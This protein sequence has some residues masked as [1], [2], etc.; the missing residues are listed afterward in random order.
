MVVLA[1]FQQVRKTIFCT[2][3]PIKVSRQYVEQVKKG[4][5]V[6]IALHDDGRVMLRRLKSGG[7]RW[8]W[9]HS[10]FLPEREAGTTY[11]ISNSSDRSSL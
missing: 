7:D 4:K 1:L 11:S 10:Q 5:A 2:I 9:S 6:S 3:R 8:G